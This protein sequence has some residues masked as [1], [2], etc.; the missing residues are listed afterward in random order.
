MCNFIIKKRVVK[1]YVGHEGQI[2]PYGGTQNEF[3]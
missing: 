2:Y 3:E 1:N